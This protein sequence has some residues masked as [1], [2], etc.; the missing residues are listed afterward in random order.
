MRR[1]K[2]V[3]SPQRKSAGGRFSYAKGGEVAP[4]EKLQK[5]D[6]SG[7]AELTGDRDAELAAST[8]FRPLNF[9]RLMEAG[10]LRVTH[11]GLPDGY[12]PDP[13]AGFSLVSAYNDAA[14]DNS[15]KWK[16]NPAMYPV[17]KKM[18]A[19]HPEWATPHKYQQIVKSAQ[20]LG[21][22]DEDIYLGGQE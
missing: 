15:R 5:M 12:N 11:T 3:S 22:S 19:E 18:F 6:L 14:G 4:W 13:N 7:Y 9:D 8:Q 20:D 2:T 10:A 21:L 1:K 17:V 16:D